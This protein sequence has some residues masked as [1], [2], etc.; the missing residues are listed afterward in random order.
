MATFTLSAVCKTQDLKHDIDTLTRNMLDV[1]HPTNKRNKPT[2]IKKW[3]LAWERQKGVIS[4]PYFYLHTLITVYQ[5]QSF[6]K[7][8][9]WMFIWW[10]EFPSLPYAQSLHHFASPARLPVCLVVC[11]DL[12]FGNDWLINSAS[13]VWPFRE[14][15]TLF[16]FSWAPSTTSLGFMS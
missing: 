6:K 9:I 14:L 4:N 10:V 12:S 7:L 8:Q 11:I 5:S 1:G 13:W 3:T 15:C 2:Q 16:S